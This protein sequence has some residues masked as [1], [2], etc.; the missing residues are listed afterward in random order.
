MIAAAIAGT[1]D[2]PVR[3]TGGWTEHLGSVFMD[4]FERTGSVVSA[5]GDGLLITA[6]EELRPVSV[7]TDIYRFSNGPASTMDDPHGPV[8]WQLQSS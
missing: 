3:I 7:R 4:A 1:P 2:S 5:D 6:P 8:C